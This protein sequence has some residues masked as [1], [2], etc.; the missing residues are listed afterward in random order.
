MYI[1]MY[2]LC[3]RQV[4]EGQAAGESGRQYGEVGLPLQSQHCQWDQQC[5]RFTTRSGARQFEGS[6]VGIQSEGAGAAFARRGAKGL[7]P[8]EPRPRTITGIDHLTVNLIQYE[9]ISTN[10]S[11]ELYHSRQAE[12]IY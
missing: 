9:I 12:S 11:S 4:R 3:R 5:I 10:L 6:S 8:I 1:C 2:I 7:G